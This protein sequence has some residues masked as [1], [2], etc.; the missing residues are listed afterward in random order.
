M[1][2]SSF[3]THGNNVPHQ[4]LKKNT[5]TERHTFG[6]KTGGGLFR[7]EEEKDRQQARKPLLMQAKKRKSD[8]SAAQ[9]LD[10]FLR[11]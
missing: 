8:S 2:N 6:T 9:D 1:T 7:K 4:T 10:I 3:R 11:H 5:A